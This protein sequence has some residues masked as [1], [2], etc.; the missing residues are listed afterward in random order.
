MN[1]DDINN[2][3]D[4][5]KRSILILETIR[6]EYI[7]QNKDDIYISALSDGIKYTSFRLQRY[8]TAHWIMANW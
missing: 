3:I 5:L 4:E 1:I 2:R 6:Q 7:E 8:Q